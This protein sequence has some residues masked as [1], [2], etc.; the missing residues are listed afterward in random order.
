[1]NRAT[2]SRTLGVRV[3]DVLSLC[4]FWLAKTPRILFV[5]ASAESKNPKNK[6]L[7]SFEKDSKSRT[8]APVDLC[9]RG[10]SHSLWIPKWRK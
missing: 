9:I 3:M 10:L 8:S 7:P 2:H 5:A 1:M 6:I 4:F